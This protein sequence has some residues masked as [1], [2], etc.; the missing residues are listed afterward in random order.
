MSIWTEIGGSITVD[1]GEH[2]SFKK[3][4]DGYWGHSYEYCLSSEQH[5]EDNR[6]KHTFSLNIRCDGYE[7]PEEHFVMWLD[8]IPGDINITVTK[9]YSLKY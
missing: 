1:F 5:K 6:V 7:F 2:F 3:N 8:S 9:Q 4:V